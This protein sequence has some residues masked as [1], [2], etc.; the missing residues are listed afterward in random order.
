MRFFVGLFLRAFLLACLPHP[1]FRSSGENGFAMSKEI[2]ARF[3]AFG[4]ATMAEKLQRNERPPWLQFRLIVSISCYFDF[5]VVLE[6]TESSKELQFDYE[7]DEEAH[8]NCKCCR[9]C[10]TSIRKPNSCRHGRHSLFVFSDT[11]FESCHSPWYVTS[12]QIH[13]GRRVNTILNCVHNSRHSTGSS[14]SLVQSNQI[15][16]QSELKFII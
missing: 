13:S 11:R 10:G 5:A 3:S 8:C 1:R 14:A 2:V 7:R 6:S 16:Q 15:M 9:C 12:T 4:Q